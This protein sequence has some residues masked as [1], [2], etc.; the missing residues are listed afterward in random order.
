MKPDVSLR[1]LAVR[2][3]VGWFGLSGNVITA[4]QGAAIIL[5]GVVT[6][7]ELRTHR[8]LWPP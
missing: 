5:G 1:Y 7:A 6:T 2:S 8:P 4:E 3:G